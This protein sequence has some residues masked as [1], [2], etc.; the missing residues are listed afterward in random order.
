MNRAR[1]YSFLTGYERDN[2]SGLDYAQSRYYSSTQGRFTSVDPE[3]AS[4]N[5]IDPQS[6][7]AYA[8]APNNPLKYTDP[9]GRRFRVCDQDGKNCVNLSDED[10]Y[11]ARRE[12]ERNGNTY[13]GNKDFYESGGVYVDGNLYYTCESR[14]EGADQQGVVELSLWN[15]NSLNSICWSAPSTITSPA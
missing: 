10:F 14:V 5:P 2:E 8:Y 9:D 11:K 13:T 3:N 4:A 15:N 1:H 12:D 7:N 6:W